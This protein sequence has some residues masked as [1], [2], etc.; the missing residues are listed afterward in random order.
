[1]ASLSIDRWW[2]KEKQVIEEPIVPTKTFKDAPIKT[3]Q[4]FTVIGKGDREYRCVC[5]VEATDSVLAD[6]SDTDVKFIS[7][8]PA[9]QIKVVE[10]GKA[11]A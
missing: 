5:Y 11:A 3:G 7:K 2:E 6:V 1:M 10:N 4:N 9:S 8:F